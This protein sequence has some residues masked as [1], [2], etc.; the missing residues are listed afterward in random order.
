MSNENSGQKPRRNPS[1]KSGN[2]NRKRSRNSQAK[3]QGQ[4]QGKKHSKNNRRNNRNRSNKQVPIRVKGL[5]AEALIKKFGELWEKSVQAR[6]MYFEYF[7]RAD[8]N[9]LEKLRLTLYRSLITLKKFENALAPSQK[10]ELEKYQ[11]EKPKDSFWGENNP[12][13]DDY[14]P[15]PSEPE[16]PHITDNQKARESFIEDS[17]VSEG[18][19]EDYQKYREEHY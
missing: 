18:S 3:G 13:A 10:E 15:P 6:K 17:E 14:G 2:R 7:H 16:D 1:K 12:E 4:A 19:I 9:R 5:G 8:K 11:G